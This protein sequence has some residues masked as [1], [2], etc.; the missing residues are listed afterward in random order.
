MGNDGERKIIN[1]DSA[2]EAIVFAYGNPISIGDLCYSLDLDR[3]VIEESLKR[4]GKTYEEEKRGVQLVRL[5]GSYQLCSRAE[6]AQAIRKALELDEPGRIG[7]AATEVLLIV[8]NFQPTTQR[9]IDDIRGVDS[10]YWISWLIERE[11]IEP[12]GKLKRRGQ[13]RAYATTREFLRQFHFES[14]SEV[15]DI[16]GVANDKDAASQKDLDLDELEGLLK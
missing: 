1:I 16:G 4:L 9:F 12:V 5:D 7:K 14:L 2:V 15:P 13:P 11:L 8:A 10:S 6:H 3:E